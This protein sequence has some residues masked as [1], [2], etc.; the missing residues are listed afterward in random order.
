MATFTPLKGLV[1]KSPALLF[2]KLND[3]QIIIW[4]A[5]VF[6]KNI[7]RTINNFIS[8]ERIL[9]CDSNSRIIGSEINGVKIISIIE[10]IDKVNIDQAIILI[11][12]P[13]NIESCTDQLL[14]MGLQNKENIYSYLQIQRPEAVVEIY[15]GKSHY[16]KIE[17]FKKIINKLKNEYDYLFQIDLSGF[18]DPIG[19]PDIMLLIDYAEQLTSA[20]I[21]TDINFPEKK[22]KEI[23]QANKLNQLIFKIGNNF[24]LNK[25]LKKLNNLSRII[26]N[27]DSEI[28]TEIRVR[29]DVYE[30]N[31]KNQKQ[32]FEYCATLGIKAV[33]A[34][35]YLNNYDQLLEYFSD[36]RT[37][38]NNICTNDLIWEPAVAIKIANNDERRDC[39]C[40]RIFPVIESD[41]SVSN[42]HLYTKFKIDSN[43]LSINKEMLYNKRNESVNC[44]VCQLKSLHRLDIEYMLN[45]GTMQYN[46]KGD[47]IVIR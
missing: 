2:E 36:E 13:Q 17:D 30:N 47:K 20:S 22:I 9:F 5:G 18:N 32:V 42:C 3:K 8:N 29:Y 31:I 12:I 15:N 41:M 35:G 11:A 1:G 14:L 24:D 46:R 34:I 21:V 25:I 4:G 39:L 33:S 10:A 37:E 6:G 26:K 40:Q 27:V 43:Y 7:K 38:K 45:K 16:I 23:I 28:K 44:R 19:H